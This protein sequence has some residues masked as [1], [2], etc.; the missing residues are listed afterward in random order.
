MSKFK[1][2][3]L[4][5]KVIIVLVVALLAIVA[6]HPNPYVSGVAI[7]GVEMNSSASIAGMVGPKANLAPMSKERIVSINNVEIKDADDYVSVVSDFKPNKTVVIKT[8]KQSYRLLTKPLVEV[9]I[10]NETEKITVIEEVWVNKTINGSVVSVLQNVSN[11]KEVP[12]TI[13]KVVG[14]ESLGLSVYNA[15][16]SNLR[17]GLDLQGGVRVL[18]APEKKLSA[19]DMSYLIDGMMQRL[20]I[21]GLS[22]VIVREAGDLSGNQ[23]VLV[24]IAGAAESEV[25]DLISKQGKFEAKIG[26]ETV[27]R[28]GQDITYVCR[29]ADCSGIDP[30]FGCSKTSDGSW[31]CRFRF[32][33]SM[34]PDAAQKQAGVTG[35]LDVI[36]ENNEQYLSE[37]LVLF[38]DDVQV[39]ELNIGAELKGKASTDIQISGSGAGTTRDEAMFNSLE[40]MKKLQTILITGSLP[41]KME[42][43]KTDTVSPALGEEFTKNALVIF[44]VSCLVVSLVIF[45]RYRKIKIALPVCITMF[46][47]I[48]LLLGVAS[49]IGWNLDLAAIAGIIITV[50][51]GVNDQIIIVDE[52]LKG[53]K[54]VAVYDWKRRI[55]KAFFII[56]GVYLTIVVAMIPLLFAGAGLLKG[57]A[58]TTIIGASVGVFITR[59]AFAATIETL[60]KE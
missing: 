17:K 25:K 32:S 53:S 21:Y 22:D 51:T 40:N 56:M 44:F 34:T 19:E 52:A 46:L 48:I 30:Q 42:I 12:K 9:T 54:G 55:K 2:L 15:P 14:T 43:K 33:I 31:A 1:N 37:K 13:T 57:F 5:L 26:N 16:T 47:E 18:L 39:D 6:I 23:F 59:P 10:L 36:T 27:F 24:E 38:L 58:L 3:F 8:S 29:S 60:L 11:V 35:K 7:R 41:V 50:G 4:N 45:A 28:G 20:N 49:L